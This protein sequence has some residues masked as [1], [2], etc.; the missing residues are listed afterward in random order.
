MKNNSIVA[1]KKTSLSIHNVNNID[2]MYAK[3]TM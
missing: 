3:D 2:I 1:I